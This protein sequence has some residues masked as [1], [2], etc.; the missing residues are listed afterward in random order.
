MSLLM[1][2]EREDGAAAAVDLQV[3]MLAHLREVSVAEHLR[4]LAGPTRASQRHSTHDA[5]GRVSDHH[6]TT[7]RVGHRLDRALVNER[8]GAYP[9]TSDETRHHPSPGSGPHRG[10]HAV[11]VLPRHQRAAT[12]GR[13]NSPRGCPR[14]RD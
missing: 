8:L 3:T 7:A 11:D 2:L 12:A 13:S 10:V 5:A 6:P 14:P 1:A 9:R 4:R